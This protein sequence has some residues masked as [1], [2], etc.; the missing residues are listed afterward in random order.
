VYA[1]RWLAL[2][3]LFIAQYPPGRLL[4]QNECDEFADFVET[5]DPALI[6]FHLIALNREIPVVTTQRGYNDQGTTTALPVFNP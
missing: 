1:A 6:A 2:S 5:R 3:L 4:Y